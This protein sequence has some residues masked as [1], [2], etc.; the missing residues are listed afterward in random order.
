MLLVTLPE[1]IA[2]IQTFWNSE[3]R[4][5]HDMSSFRQSRN[6][7]RCTRPG[8]ILGLKLLEPDRQSSASA[9]TANNR[10]SFSFN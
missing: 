7:S 1:I 2:R 3:W 4:V 6:L 9:A 8:L 5:F 10:R